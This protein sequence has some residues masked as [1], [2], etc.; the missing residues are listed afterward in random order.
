MALLL[1]ASRTTHDVV[2]AAGQPRDTKMSL[3]LLSSRGGHQIVFAV[4]VVTSAR[5]GPEATGYAARTTVIRR[6]KS[7]QARHTAGRP[8]R[9]SP[10]DMN[11]TSI[12]KN[13]GAKTESKV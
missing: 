13:G 2:A 3:L 9:E 10:P 6:Q 7:L 4:V 5:T 1:L 11:I 8:S 12:G